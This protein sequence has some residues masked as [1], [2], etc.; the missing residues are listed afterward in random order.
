MSKKN[1]TKQNKN[2]TS[3]DQEKIIPRA[4][5]R[6]IGVIPFVDSSD[7]KFYREMRKRT[8]KELADQLYD[9]VCNKNDNRSAMYLAFSHLE[10]AKFWYANNIIPSCKIAEEL[11]T[12]SIPANANILDIGGGP[13]A[14]AFW[15]AH[16]WNDCHV[17]VADKF[18]EIGTKWAMEIGMDRVTFIN[19]LLPE[20]RN[21]PDETFDVIILSR[22]LRHVDGIKMPEFIHNNNVVDYLCSEEG[23]DFS[24]RFGSLIK[25]IKR[26]LTP[27]GHVVIVDEWNE[28]NVFV[29]CKIMEQYGLF[30]DGSFFKYERVSNEFSVI[31]LSPSIKTPDDSL[32]LCMGMSAALSFP[33]VPIPLMG[34]LAESVRKLFGNTTPIMTFENETFEGKFKWKNEILEKNGIA[35][36][37]IT[38]NYCDR[39]AFLYPAVAIPKLLKT[40]QCNTEQ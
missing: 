31:A 10:L 40:L 1:K 27:N 28:L 37:Y 18:P 38:N 16:I 25:N 33:Q 29:T 13:G 6:K 19:S 11:A 26:V 36:F 20:L 14:I 39:K 23:I 34:T 35:L 8:G 3:H 24:L 17:T 22:V 4:F 15:M 9:L 7:A 21:L 30:I 5:F 2:S 32:D 12:I